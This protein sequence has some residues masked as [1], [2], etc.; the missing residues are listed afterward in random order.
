MAAFEE[1]SENTCVSFHAHTSEADYL[2]FTKGYGCASYLGRTGGEQPIY[3]GD[4]CKTGNIV[5]E[6]MHALGFHHEHM[7]KDRDDYVTVVYSN[8]IPHRMRNF[9]KIRG[10]TQGLPYD[11]ESIMHYG[12]RFFSVNGKDTIISKDTKAIGQRIQLSV[13]D[14]LRVQLLY[15]CGNTSQTTT[16]PV[17]AQTTTASVNAQTTTASLNAQTTT[18]SLKTQ[19]TTASLKAQTTTAN[20]QTTTAPLKAQ[21]TTAP[22]NAQTTTASL[23]AQT[24]TASVNAQ[25]TT[26][27]GMPRLQ[28]F[29]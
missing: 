12:Q 3:I 5:H 24:T 6:I 7:R 23:K 21:T 26:V 8:I 29:R 13:L 2:L 18:A 11:T 22:V 9:A 15:K 17:N 14:I 1:I 10:D 28:L 20:A 19:T 25:I 27:P 16:A 4:R